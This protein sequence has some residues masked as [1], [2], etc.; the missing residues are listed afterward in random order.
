MRFS[1]ANVDTNNVNNSKGI[2]NFSI[3]GRLFVGFTIITTIT[4]I[5]VMFVLYWATAAKQYAHEVIT[6]DL[7]NYNTL[8]QIDGYV[9]QSHSLLQSW[10][11]TNNS[12][13]KAD[14]ASIINKL[15]MTQLKFNNT[16]S[17]QKNRLEMKNWPEIN[18]LLNRIK[19]EQTQVENMTDSKEATNAFLAGPTVT[20]DKVM[21]LL[22]GTNTSL[23]MLTGYYHHVST[24]TEQIIIDMNYIRD[25][26]LGLIISTILFGI[27]IAMITAKKIIAPLSM[28]RLHSSK[29]ASGDLTQRVD[30][31]SRDELG[32]LGDD[33]NTMTQ[34][35]SSITKNIA[36]AST[37]MATSLEEVKQASDQ[38]SA[39]VSQQAASIN[40][41]T[42]S[43]EEIDKSAA[44]TMEKARILGQLAETT[45]EQGQAG[46]QAVYDS[47]EGMKAVR[48]KVETIAKNILDLSNQ[49]QQVGEITAVVNTLAQQS[50]MLAL[51]ASIE[52]AKAGDSGKGFAVVAT[53][54]KNLAEQSEQSTV[55]VQRILEDIRRAT[56]KAVLV[57]EEGTKGV[58]QGTSLVEQM[59][60]IVRSLTQA[61][62]ETRIA[63][64]QIEAAVRQESLGI[65][66][67]TTG[68][69]EINQVTSS[70]VAT[71][72]QTSESIRQLSGIAKNIK[73]YVDV[74]KVS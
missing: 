21:N 54:I 26:L 36:Q 48:N 41:I 8:S 63:S 37:N 72:K 70:F 51:N 28:F 46:L 32:K 38:Q 16:Y 2:F 24:N 67:I 61:I 29:V 18:T 39:G 49:T 20:L 15:S 13:F 5:A 4:V 66:Q 69:N 57:T 12:K 52:A 44:Q 50:K 65:E 56:E 33:L 43:L 45:S 11:L 62:Q 58:D 42:A 6:T 22:Y 74:Y 3:R 40:E 60:E 34:G 68:M 31:T 30:V 10:L 71:V 19:N 27:I 53:E 1:K 59:G 7:P 73:E 23:G 55:E 47:I 9:Y 35:L 25:I 64:Q 17:T 14:R